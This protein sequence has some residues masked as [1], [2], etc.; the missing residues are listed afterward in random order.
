MGIIRKP[1]ELQV[2]TT[3]K[4]L[5]YGQPGIG[6]T[7]LALSAPSPLLLDFDNGV[8]RVDPRHQ[9]D[10]VQI[11]SWEDM[12][13]LLNEDIKSYKTLV[14][15]T[16]GKMLDFMSAHLIKTDSK[17]G[18]RD[19]SLSLQGYGARKH[20]FSNFLKQVA[21]LGK[22]LVFVAHE[23]EEKD[24]DIKIIR[25]EIGGSSGGDLVKELDL[26]G[27]MEAIGKKRTISFDPSEKFYGKNTCDLDPQMEITD[28]KTK[29]NV[30]LSSIFTQYHEALDKRKEMAVAY[31]AMIENIT[32]QV[33]QIT[34]AEDANMFI[35]WITSTEHIWDTKLQAG[36]LFNDRTKVLGL[37]RLPDNTYDTKTPVTPTPA[38]QTAVPARDPEPE[39]AK[40][41]QTVAPATAPK[42]TPSVPQL[43]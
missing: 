6:K 39:P 29:P 33:A 31:N 40:A 37:K 23:K 21:I 9:T 38:A 34:D 26:V 20:M 12:E 2:Q 41:E 1:S 42:S 24:G 30:L 32:A 22:H 16:A 18:K 25:P 28:V 19:G 13:Q 17:L 11:T 4:I 35:G 5:L 10:T 8:H 15:D 7:T 14:I 43:F 3:I 27:Y 36:R